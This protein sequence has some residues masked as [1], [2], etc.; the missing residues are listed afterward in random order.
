MLNGNGKK[1]YITIPSGSPMQGDIWTNLPFYECDLPFRFA[2]LITPKCDF[3]HEKTK[4]FNYIP[5]LS[6]NEYMSYQGYSRLLNEELNRKL[7]ALYNLNIQLF[8]YAL[9]EIGASKKDV[10][11]K[12]RAECSAGDKKTIAKID[13]F[14]VLTKEIMLLR[15][16]IDRHKLNKMEIEST[17]KEKD[18]KR[19]LDQIVRNQITDLHFLP[20]CPPFLENPSVLFLRYLSTCHIDIINT[21]CNCVNEDDWKFHCLK[22][23][24][25]IEVFKLCKN[26][27]ERILRLKSPY[28]ENLMNRIG[29]LYLRV[30]TPDLTRSEYT[31]AIKGAL[32]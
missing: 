31:S 18:V 6:I 32:K 19:H 1:Y 3:A 15:Q 20:A 30:G 24:A 13:K 4:V 26:K 28:L 8:S 23:E 9:L 17:I 27:P 29:L 21:A 25:T 12:M 11:K 2:L 5:A 16:L 10:C 22:K 14:E 7:N